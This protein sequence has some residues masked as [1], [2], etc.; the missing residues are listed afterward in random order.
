MV[1]ILGLA[2]LP[3]QV[4][5]GVIPQCRQIMEIPLELELQPGQDAEMP[6]QVEI[7]KKF[8]LMLR[9]SAFWM[10]GKRLHLLATYFD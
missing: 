5:V 1:R 8:P 6:K 3:E 7:E 2:T 4:Q 10:L 9:F